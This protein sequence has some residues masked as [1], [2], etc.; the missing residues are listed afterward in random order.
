MW[1]CFALVE[2]QVTYDS[3]EIKASPRRN[4][5]MESKK[6]IQEKKKKKPKGNIQTHQSQGKRYK[7][8]DL[9]QDEQLSIC[10]YGRED[11]S[12]RQITFWYLL[13]KHHF[14]L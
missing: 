3:S 9:W 6:F 10:S 12:L 7:S 1:I 8:K 14:T 11:Y 13:F 5:A 2:G 4:K